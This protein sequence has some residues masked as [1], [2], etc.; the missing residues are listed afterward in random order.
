M[1]NG[2]M[3]RGPRRH[4]WDGP[5]PGRMPGQPPLSGVGQT[6]GHRRYGAAERSLDILQAWAI[7]SGTLE[8]LGGPD[9]R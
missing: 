8:K 1:S 2:R 9:A 4:E 7:L 5:A 6:A 3:D